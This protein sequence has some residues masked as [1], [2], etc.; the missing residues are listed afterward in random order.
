M[1]HWQRHY[2]SEPAEKIK[3]GSL[4]GEVGEDTPL[5][6]SQ[7]FTLFPDWAS[8]Y[9]CNRLTQRWLGP[10]RNNPET[11][12]Q[13]YLIDSP[14]LSPKESPAISWGRGKPRY[15]AGWRTEWMSGHWLRDTEYHHAP[16]SSLDTW[17]PD[18][19]WSFAKIQLTVS[20]LRS[21]TRSVIIS[22]PG[23]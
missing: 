11:I 17:S 6:I 21:W 12:W 10:G 4:G 3:A 1:D 19:K 9:N 8:F 2:S 7:V 15:Y 18:N 13:L 23:F 16:S 5:K 14:G 20:S 22:D